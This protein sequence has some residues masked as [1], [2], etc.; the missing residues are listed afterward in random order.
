MRAWAEIDLDAI[1]NNIR[2]IRERT[3]TK[4]MVMA[5]VKADAYGHGVREVTKTLL[6]NG[7]DRLAVATGN[8]H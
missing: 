8:S 7:A 2:I 4:A 3:S 5:V 6:E 1:K